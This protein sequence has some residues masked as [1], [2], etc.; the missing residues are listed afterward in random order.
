MGTGTTR[1]STDS[2]G[3]EAAGG[4][5]QVTA[6]SAD[7][8][9]VAFGSF[10]TNLVAGDTNGQQDSFIKDTVTG[11]TTRVSTDSA[12]NQATGGVG[13]SVTA[14]SADGR[15]VAFWSGATNLVAGDTNG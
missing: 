4:L 14:I 9:Y 8:R 15:Y 10:A 6:L 7:G 11:V 3:N 13:S 1:V 2:A 12:G 5:S